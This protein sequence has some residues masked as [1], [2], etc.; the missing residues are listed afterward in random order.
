M[1]LLPPCL[2]FLLAIGI[3]SCARAPVN[4]LS[5][6]TEMSAGATERRVGDVDA[7][8][9]LPCDPTGPEPCPDPDPAALFQG[10]LTLVASS[11]SVSG[12]TAGLRLGTAREFQSVIAPPPPGVPPREW[13]GKFAGSRAWVV[14]NV[15]P[16]A[17]ELIVS[18]ETEPDTG[19]GVADRATAIPSFVVAANTSCASG[20]QLETRGTFTMSHLGKTAV[21]ETHCQ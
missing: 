19:G 20:F 7:V 1:R 18:I 4:S 2:V 16:D 13:T 6:T 9:G 12:P 15:Q 8:E 5:P 3:S 21:T 10:F 14:L 17:A 11:T